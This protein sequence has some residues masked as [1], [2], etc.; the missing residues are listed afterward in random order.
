MAKFLRKKPRTVRDVLEGLGVPAETIDEAEAAGTAELLAIDAVVVPER[1][2]LTIDELA[3]KVGIDVDDVRLFWRGLGFVD[4]PEGERSFNKRDVAILKSL[5]ALARNGLIDPELALQ[6]ARVLGVSM[7]Q[8]ATALVDASESR[9]GVRRRDHSDTESDG[10]EASGASMVDAGPLAV[11]AGDILPFMS[12]V[13]DYSFRRHLRAAARRRILVAATFD[14]VTEVIGFA[15]LVRFTELSSQLD[16]RELAALIGRFDELVNLTVVRH[17]GRV[18]KMIGDAAMFSVVEPDAAALIALELSEAAA[19][20]DV[21]PGLRIGMANGPVVARDGDLY[22]PVVNTASRLVTIGRAGAINVSQGVRD[23]LAGDRRF[24]LRSLGD[25]HLRHIGEV[26]VYRLRS[27]ADW[28][29]PS[30]VD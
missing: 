3:A 2:K 5:V 19:R 13:I 27:G 6:V 9:S 28:T 11:R 22:G 26:R 25:R 14:G 30:Q 12:E 24:A 1:A 16:E 7:A 15:D 17:G 20:D 23:A 4:V 29:P 10:D 8:V 18:V 21:L